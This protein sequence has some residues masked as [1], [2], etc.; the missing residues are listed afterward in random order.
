MKKQSF[1]LLLMILALLGMQAC[2][3]NPDIS[4]MSEEELL[5]YAGTVH[6]KVL[7]LDSHVDIPGG[8]YAT[9]E[10]D[11]GSEE[12]RL[13]CTLPKMEKGGLDGVFLAVYVGQDSLVPNKYKK[14]HESA[15][16]KFEA[17]HRLAEEMYPERCELAFNADDIVRIEKSG[18]RAIIIG[19][20]NAYPLGTEIEN[21]KKY[22]DSGTRYITLSHYGNNQ[23]CTS[24]M[25][26]ARIG[27]PPEITYGLTDYGKEFISEMNKLGIIVDVSHISRE[28]FW[29]IIKHSKAPVIASHGACK[30]LNN[31]E[32][33]FDD[34]QL[35]AVAKN[36]G[37]VQMIAFNGFM[38]PENPDRTEALE[39]LNKKYGNMRVRRSELDKMSSK[40]RADFERK[41][42]LYSKSRQEIDGKF[43][44][45]NENY[46]DY[47]D[48]LDH[49]IKIA[50][51]DYV[52]IGS[53]FD[54]GGGVEGF[55]GHDDCLNITVELLRRGYSEKEIYKIW[56]GNLLR[57]LRDVEKVASEL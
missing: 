28:A 55:N 38:K 40:A 1:V 26:M 57:V 14:A 49:A 17:I 53:D 36:G 54:G 51:I 32:R 6:G 22:Y 47:V 25:P 18:K 46:K 34:D 5:K 41:R 7:T 29:D 20:E 33:A 39:E 50:G 42:E 31:V 15:L 43:P 27:D 10:L 12:T 23:V 4:K 48:H 35:R 45:A 9:T 2:S 44:P 8:N 24:A 30:A 19:V 56:G 37:T 11:P 13:Q 16:A 3:Q 52:G 21:L